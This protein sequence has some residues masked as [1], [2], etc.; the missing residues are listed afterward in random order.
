MPNALTTASSLL[1]PHGGTI[2]GTPAEGKVTFD[3]APAL[4]SGDSFQI[5]GCAFA[6]PSG[7]PS[8]CLTVEW[9]VSDRKT[10]IDDV[11]TL[12]DASVGLCKAGSGAPQGSVVIA[13]TQMK[14]QTS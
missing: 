4:T 9:S 1:C 8:P 11:A 10:M 13:S 5:A 12:S 3:G 7:T 14:G 6:L 2:T